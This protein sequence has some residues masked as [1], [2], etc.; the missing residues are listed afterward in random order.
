MAS[1][2]PN[3]THTPPPTMVTAATGGS[4]ESPEEET[5]ILTE[6]SASVAV[7]AAANN[8]GHPV[9]HSNK[10]MIIDCID[11]SYFIVVFDGG[12]PT[13]LFVRSYYSIVGVAKMSLDDGLGDFFLCCVFY[14]Q[15]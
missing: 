7:V 15:E 3:R 13:S 1:T 4:T 10:E 8:T 12:T 5:S 6:T 9:T 11:D 14:R 2:N